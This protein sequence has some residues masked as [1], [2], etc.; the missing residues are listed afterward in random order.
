[1]KRYKRWFKGF[2]W[3]EV[4]VQKHGL[5]G[6]QQDI[7]VDNVFDFDDFD[8]GALDYIQYYRERLMPQAES[9]IY[10]KGQPGFIDY[11]FNHQFSNKQRV[12]I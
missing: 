8:R 7:M 12:G 6:F 3:A 11:S 4:Q 5:R 9:R 2:K 1:M 10:R